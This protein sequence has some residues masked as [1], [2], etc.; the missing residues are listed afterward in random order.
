MFNWKFLV[1]QML[2]EQETLLD[3]VLF[4]LGGAAVVTTFAADVQADI[5]VFGAADTP[6]T[7]V[8]RPWIYLH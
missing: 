5:F 2:P 6:R 7:R 8:H 4:A 1:L 3:L